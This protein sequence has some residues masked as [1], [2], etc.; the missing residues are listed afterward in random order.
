MLLVSFWRQPLV[1]GCC[2]CHFEGGLRPPIFSIFLITLLVGWCVRCSM[3]KV[4]LVIACDYYHFEG[5]LRPP[6]S[7]NNTPCWV[8]C[9]MSNV[10]LVIGCDY[11]HF[12]GGLRPPY[13]LITLL[14]GWCV[15]YPT[16]LLSSDVITAI[17]KAACGRIGFNNT[18]CWVMC[19]I[20][21]VTLS[22]DVITAILK[23]AFG[24]IG[25]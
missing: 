9:S 1:I 3:S 10:T 22:S 5:G 20:S 23:A 13:F 12:E 2:H 21:H 7:F 11:C 4:T 24:R 8:M 17:L 19:S 18:P 15:R 6:Q 25:F 14:L 16:L